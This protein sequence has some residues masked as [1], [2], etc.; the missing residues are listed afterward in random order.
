MPLVD[1][2]EAPAPAARNDGEGGAPRR[3]RSRAVLLTLGAVGAVL[4]GA[5]AYELKA[6][7]FQSWA[8]HRVAR[9]A[10]WS[11]GEGPS[12]RIRFPTAG[13]FDE[14]LGY[15]A[16]PA[17]V[18][19]AAGRGFRV[20]EQARV[21]DGFSRLID[22][23]AAPVYQEKP[24]GG[25]TLKDRSGLPFHRTLHP[26]LVYAAFDSIP[27]PMWR[28]LLHIESRELLDEA[29]PRRNPAVEWDRLARGVGEIGLRAIGSERSVPGGSTLATQLEKFRHSPGGRTATPRDKLDQMLG[30]SLRAYRDG[31]ETVEARRRIVRDYLNS[32]PLAAQRGHG[33]VIGM[34]DGLWAWYGTSFEDANRVLGTEPTDSAGRAERARVYRQVLS[35]LLAHRRPS[36]YL[37]DPAGRAALG[38][39]T[40]RYLDLLARDGIVPVDLAERSAR[41]S[42]GLLPAAPP[43]PAPSFV[44]RKAA[45]QVRSDLLAITGVQNLYA[46]DRLDLTVATT[47]DARLQEGVTS[48]FESLR[49][50][51]FVRSHGFG[52]A[53]LLGSQDPTH[54]LYSFTLLESTPGG[55]VVRAQADSYDGPLSLS[56]AGRVELG[57]TA[58]L[59]TL[60]TYL[61]VV[62]ELHGRL[63]ALAADSLAALSVAR[64]DR[65]TRWAV[66]YVAANPG[67][68]LETM[69]RD[70]MERRY[71]A[72]PTERFAT[73]G[74]VQSF[75]NFDRA[76]D[77]RVLS[78]AEAFRQSVNLPFVRLMRDVVSY[79]T[80]GDPGSAARAL[81]DPDHPARQEYLERF[82]DAEGGRFVRSF[83]AKYADVAASEILDRLVSE[84]RLTARATAAAYRAV[85]PDAPEGLFATF[86]RA[87]ASQ[88]EI[89]DRT[90]STL[91]RQSDPAT[92]DLNDLG[93]LSRIHPLEL[94]TARYLVEHPRAPLSETLEASRDARR[95]VYR[96]LFRSRNRGA[97][98]DRIRTVLE[99]EAFDR[100]L[101]SWRRVGYPFP[102]I[103][104]SLGTAIGSSGDR[105]LALAELMGIILND[106]VRRP[107]ARVTG[108]TFAE[109]TPFETRLE[110][111][112]AEGERVLASEVAATVR[113][114]LLD[115]VANGTGRRAQGAVRDAEGN[116]VPIGAKT[117]TG[118]NRYRVFGPGGRLI[119]DRVVNRTA[120]FA[121]I[122]GDRHFGVLTAYVPG[123]AAGSFAFTSALPAEI[124]RQIGPLLEVALS[125]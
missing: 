117:G 58:K 119:E 35:L 2:L 37:A 105:P 57:S 88:P 14:R 16:I 12:D 64:G 112:S 41:A 69:L 51:E 59:R 100:V 102:N 106:G 91:Y 90:I 118:D 113:T 27:E 24:Q 124:V 125:G 30:A 93:Y 32:V 73:G 82:A 47:F 101:A 15:T 103:V 68:S 85:A 21:S 45:N 28:S 107:F 49:D 97:Q 60:V 25:L 13:P 40:D 92:R 67:A 54:V 33:E 81:E 43:R 7:S 29:Y 36:Y 4:L 109:G 1:A 122:L 87:N 111:E 65:L 20:A 23:G 104:P 84:R 115:V 38:P 110:R 48:F 8:F 53:R 19:R 56:E 74:G 6:S 9:E 26:A 70:A 116:P 121:F 62:A 46:L 3:R 71:S 72:S 94:W 31:A 83:H 114:A 44:T 52:D 42:I 66:D 108:M 123:P 75:S 86:L 22:W 80:Y 78:V 39:L 18:D 77:A 10:V 34:A 95:E 99:I 76:S 120:T 89:D 50:P 96:W 61:E 79:H 17:M 55:N 11:V 63:S 98:D 5:V